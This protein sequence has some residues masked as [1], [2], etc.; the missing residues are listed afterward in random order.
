[1][2]HDDKLEKGNFLQVDLIPE[3]FIRAICVVDA[4]IR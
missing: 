3:A 4:H 1:L 2:D